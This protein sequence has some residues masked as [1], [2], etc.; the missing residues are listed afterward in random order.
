MDVRKHAI[1][2][3]QIFIVRIYDLGD[4]LE[5]IALFLNIGFERQA[6]QTQFLLV[7]GLLFLR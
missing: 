2:L 6:R 3:D 4:G 1:H 7:I 5:F